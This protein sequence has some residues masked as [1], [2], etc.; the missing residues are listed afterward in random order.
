MYFDTRHN[1]QCVKKYKVEEI[2]VIPNSS[3]EDSEIKCPYCGKS[4][5]KRT[6]GYFKTTKLTLEEENYSKN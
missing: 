6:A 3:K 2:S 1:P 4:Y 5:E